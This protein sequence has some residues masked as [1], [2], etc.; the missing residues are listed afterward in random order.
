MT[1]EAEIDDLS[2]CSF[3]VQG[4]DQFVNDL[5]DIGFVGLECRQTNTHSL[6]AVCT[7]H[8]ILRLDLS[9]EWL[10]LLLARMRDSL[11]P[12]L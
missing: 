2:R 11:R 9:G 6:R 12:G 4:V 5:V 1:P 7:W 10:S 3:L 8:G